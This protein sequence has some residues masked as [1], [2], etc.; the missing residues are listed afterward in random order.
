MTHSPE[1]NPGYIG[2]TLKL[3]FGIKQVDE[4]QFFTVDKAD[5]SSVRPSSSLAD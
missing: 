1:S 5:V 3:I 2:G 4:G